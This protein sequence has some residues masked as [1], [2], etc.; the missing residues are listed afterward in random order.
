MY[1]QQTVPNQMY[2]GGVTFPEKELTQRVGGRCVRFVEF[3]HL[4]DATHPKAIKGGALLVSV[5][6]WFSGAVQRFEA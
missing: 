1:A 4:F 3:K 2:L 6:P 5:A